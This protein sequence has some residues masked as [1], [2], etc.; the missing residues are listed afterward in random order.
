M[1]SDFSFAHY[2]ELFFSLFGQ[3]IITKLAHDFFHMAGNLT[4]IWCICHQ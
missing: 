1:V 2:R 4:A 3:G